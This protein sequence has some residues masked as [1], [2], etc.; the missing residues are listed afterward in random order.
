MYKLIACDIDGTL[1]RSDLTLSDYTRETI[2]EAM[3]RDVHFILATGRIFGSARIYA[4]QLELSAPII[5]CNGGVI[6]DLQTG[7]KLFGKP[8]DKELCKDIFR[9]LDEG[10]RYFHFY[11][12][13]NFYS[14]RLIFDSQRMNQW[15]MTL[16]LEDRIPILEVQDP[17]SIPD[18]DPIYKILFHATDPADRLYYSELFS[19]MP[20]ITL[21]S[22][23]KNNFE[24]CGENVNKGSALDDYAKSLGINA[25][26]V[27]AF[28][29]ND[30]DI[31]MISYAG[32]GVAV[33]NATKKLRA[34]ADY[35]TSSN[36]D[37]GVAKAIQRFV[38]GG[39]S[40]VK[41]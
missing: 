33:E 31:D 24:I 14:E 6:K 19:T 32:M 30:N 9:I 2:R 5:T 1:I 13:D 34:V 21:S 17:Y 3:E 39:G 38:L 12:E 37:D 4:R 40:N 18:K 41:D 27:I 16:P 8:I 29:D 20:G 22:S 35:I 36:E 7:E 26:Q 25:S 28:G 11:G 15:N 10:H 23:W